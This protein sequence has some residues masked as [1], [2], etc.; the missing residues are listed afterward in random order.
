M[1]RKQRLRSTA[2]PIVHFKRESQQRFV[3]VYDAHNIIFC[4]GP[5]GTAKTWCAVYCAVK[6]FFDP[7]KG[8]SQVVFTR[9]VIEAAGE[10]IGFLPGSLDEK[11]SPYL[12][13]I[14]N[15][16]NTILPQNEK[17]REVTD[18][19]NKFL[20]A[21]IAKPV[22]FMRG[23]TFDDA[24]CIMDEAQNA[25]K[26]VLELFMTRLGESEN[27]KMILIGDIDQKDTN[28]SYFQ[29]CFDIF[30]DEDEI[31]FFKFGIEDIVRHKLVGRIVEIMRDA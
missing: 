26:E 12:T 5:A 3:D 21:C 6:D 9:P 22:S 16:L 23:D 14:H 2:F 25:T 10:K 15:N 28:K 30:R 11:F 7:S 20:K 31:G 18:K 17:D 13:P 8:I 4:Q 29:K 24:I 1:S 27:N 19:R